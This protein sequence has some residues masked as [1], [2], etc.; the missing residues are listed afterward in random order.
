[1]NDSTYRDGW[2]AAPWQL[3][4]FALYLLTTAAGELAFL[5]W[6]TPELAQPTSLR[7]MLVWSGLVSLALMLPALKLRAKG[8]RRGMLWILAVQAVYALAWVALNSKYPPVAFWAIGASVF[9]IGMLSAASVR[10]FCSVD[11]PGRWRT[12]S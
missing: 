8:S 10:R 12:S 9:W 2:R 11:V 6:G 5:L 3:K 4:V 7:R 1:M